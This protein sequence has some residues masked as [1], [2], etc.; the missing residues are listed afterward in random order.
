MRLDG[1][2]LGRPPHCARAER[3]HGPRG[4]G[5]LVARGDGTQR[6]ESLG[7]GVRRRAPVGRTP[8][9]R[10]G[11][12][13]PAWHCR[14]WLSPPPR[15]AP[16]SVAR[17]RGSPCL[18]SPWITRIQ[19]LG[20]QRQAKLDQQPVPR[21]GMIDFAHQPD[22]VD[23]RGV[24]RRLVADG[25]DDASASRLPD[26]APGRRPGAPP[27]CELVSILAQRGIPQGRGQR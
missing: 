27:T 6:R 14:T 13:V 18:A 9:R 17:A 20:A 4:R 25:F 1:G 22:G 15:P 11:A 23:A 12:P 19:R 16:R 10:D 26:P 5:L 7:Q 21:R 2:P 24:P 3:V 8:P